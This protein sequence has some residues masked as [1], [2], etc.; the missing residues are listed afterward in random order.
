M[1]TEL[2]SVGCNCMLLSN[3]YIEICKLLASPQNTSAVQLNAV[4]NYLQ[5]LVRGHGELE[6]LFGG[7]EAAPPIITEE[8][9]GIRLEPLS[10]GVDSETDDTHENEHDYS[11]YCSL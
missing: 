10:A 11:T 7:Y 1:A 2:E 8:E 6:R 5:N 3:K 4:R 9:I